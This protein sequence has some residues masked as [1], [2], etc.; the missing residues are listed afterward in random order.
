MLKTKIGNL[1]IWYDDSIDIKRVSS[2]IKNNYFLFCEE[3]KDCMIISFVPTD[4][5]V[6]YINDIDDYL[7]E[8]YALIYHSK[9]IY[10][11]YT[12]AHLENIY[13]FHLIKK[14]L[15]NGEN[16]LFELDKR[17]DEEAWDKMFNMI[18]PFCY[19]HE[20]GCFSDY[21]NYMKYRDEEEKN[22]MLD[23][24]R[25][26]YRYPVFNLVQEFIVKKIQ[27]D[28]YFYQNLR[29]I[30]DI[31][32]NE[33]DKNIVCDIK[34]RLP[35]ASPKRIHELMLQFL[36]FIDM[37]DWLDKYQELCEKNGIIY[38]MDGQSSESSCCIDKNGQLKIIV[39]SNGT[40]EDF[41][42]LVH[43]F[44][45]YLSW[46]DR[47]NLSKISIQEFPSIFFEKIAAL[48]LVKC[49]YDRK[50]VTYFDA[51]RCRNNVLNALKLFPLF[52]NIINYLDNGPV[53]L[54]SEIV[55]MNDIIENYNKNHCQKISLKDL[56]AIMEIDDFTSVEDFFNQKYDYLT[57]E[58]ITNGVNI[59]DG[60]QYI[61]G[62]LLAEKLI[63]YLDWKVIVQVI[64]VVNNF[65]DYDLKKILELFDLE[66]IFKEKGL[67]K[68]K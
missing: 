63:D 23:W 36:S 67:Q 17:F 49:G 46:Q 8:A 18:L 40:V 11:S 41:F 50:V 60:F 19:Y 22:K 16:W 64:D 30:M 35:Q 14:D 20:N 57:R 44:I 38:Y 32:Y 53:S 24:L 4:E 25:E 65:K 52:S 61:I 56:F 37:P 10:E 6:T 45:H 1:E 48:F 26:K 58:M 13:F 29:N 47:V 15:K 39:D 33:I 3:A 42:S 2:L 62:T 66:D 68:T 28:E 7:N 31:I 55:R 34:D 5:E 27:L 9:K 43:E 21:L 51:L 54:E 12:N 59:F